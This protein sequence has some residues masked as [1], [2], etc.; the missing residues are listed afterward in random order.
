MPNILNMQIY[1]I[2]QKWYTEKEAKA[3][4][5]RAQKAKGNLDGDSY[6]LSNI[7]KE[8][9]WLSSDER[10]IVRKA[11]Q[12]GKPTYMYKMEQGRVVLANK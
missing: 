4:A 11:K 9:S 1:N 7:W 2:M 3:I 5:Y 12:T 8:Y 6:R 10:K